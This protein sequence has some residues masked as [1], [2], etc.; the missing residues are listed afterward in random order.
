MEGS[1]TL[2]CEKKPREASLSGCFGHGR[3][4]I[5][6][7]SKSDKGRL[8]GMHVQCGVVGR[9]ASFRRSQT[10]LNTLIKGYASQLFRVLLN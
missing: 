8:A 5:A 2:N 10:S 3:R 7:L 6:P 4:I 9:S 1:K